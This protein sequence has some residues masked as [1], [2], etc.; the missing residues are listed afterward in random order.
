MDVIVGRCLNRKTSID[1]RDLSVVFA[2]LCVFV[3][4]ILVDLRGEGEDS[5]LVRWMD[6]SC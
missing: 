6:L 2:L 1:P 5:R 4:D 3:C